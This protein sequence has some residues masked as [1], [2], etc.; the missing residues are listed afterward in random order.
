MHHIS[1]SANV[2]YSLPPRL[3]FTQHLSVYQ[4]L[5]TQTFYWRRICGLDKQE[6]IKF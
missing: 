1:S 2:A 5:H 4:Q 6:K 3:R